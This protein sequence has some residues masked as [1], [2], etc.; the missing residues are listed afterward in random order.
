[1]F[2]CTYSLGC[3]RRSYRNALV[4]LKIIEI[5]RF[6]AGGYKLDCV[7]TSPRSFV[8]PRDLRLEGLGHALMNLISHPDATMLS[9]LKAN[10]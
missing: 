5:T 2:V 8:N 7:Q 1:M 3:I 9:G 4:T 6:G 10:S